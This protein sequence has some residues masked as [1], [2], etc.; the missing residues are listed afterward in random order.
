MICFILLFC[1]MRVYDENIKH[2]CLNALLLI[3][4]DY[5]IKVYSFYSLL[6]ALRFKRVYLILNQIF[7]F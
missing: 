4:F 2:S 5:N 3:K 6:N 7:Y 1:E